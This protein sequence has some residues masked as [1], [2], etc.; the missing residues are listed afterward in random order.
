MYQSSEG[1]SQALLTSTIEQHPSH[2]LLISCAPSVR[3]FP[4]SLCIKIAVGK[5]ILAGESEPWVLSRVLSSVKSNPPASSD[6]DKEVTGTTNILSHLSACDS[7]PV[8]LCSVP[9]LGLK[10]SAPS[11]E[12]RKVQQWGE[13]M[14]LAGT[15]PSSRTKQ[16]SVH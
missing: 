9:Y 16:F 13:H 2:H 10:L 12:G 1:S 3:I 5:R 14:P 15:G 11:G 6:D 7:I 8:H 4:A